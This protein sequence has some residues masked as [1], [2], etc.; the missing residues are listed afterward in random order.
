MSFLDWAASHPM[1]IV[2]AALVLFTLA[3]TLRYIP[4]NRVGILEKLWSGAGSV[5]SGLIALN[6]EAGFQPLVLRGRSEERRV[7]K[8]CRL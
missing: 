1:S 7:G 5:K 8:E 2:L 4:N 3:K 6:G